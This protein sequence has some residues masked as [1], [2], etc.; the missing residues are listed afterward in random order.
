MSSSSSQQRPHADPD[1]QKYK[2]MCNQMLAISPKVRYAG[3]MNRFGRTL[4]GS[5]RKGVVP[6]LKPEEAKSEYFIEAARNEMRRSFEKSIGR[7]EYT[8]T[9]NEKVRIV[10]IMG[11]EQHLYYVTI[12]KDA[13]AQEVAKIIESARKLAAI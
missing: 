9:E 10:T 11:K 12:D 1:T 7:T 6:L 13:S 4:A 2:E 3:I 5:L 8:L